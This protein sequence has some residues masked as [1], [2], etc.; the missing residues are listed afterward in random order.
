MSF[1]KLEHE[2]IW[3]NFKENLESDIKCSSQEG[4]R[5]VCK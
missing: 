2:K 4:I 3:F 1:A 5:V